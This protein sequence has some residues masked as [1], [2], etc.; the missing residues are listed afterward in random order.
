MS[1]PLK[2]KIDGL[3]VR[4]R[5]LVTVYALGWILGASLAAVLVLGL[6][7]YLLRFQDRG[8]R[9]ICFLVL[10]GVIGWS[11]YRY[12]VLGLTARLADVELARRLQRRFPKLGDGLASAVEFLQQSEEDPT[13]GSIALRRAVIA[14]TTAEVDQ[15]DVRS[16][17]RRGPTFRVIFTSLAICLVALV[18]VVVDPLSSRI[19]VARLINPFGNLAWPQTYHLVLCEEVTTVARGQAFEVEVVDQRGLRLP[20]DVRIHYRFQNAD[21]TVTEEAELMRLVDGA[22]A[23]RRSNGALD[24]RRR[25]GVMVARRE[26]VSRPFSYR[27]E[28]GD[29][30]VMPWIPVEVAEPPG[31]ESLAITL[32]PPEY[33]GW[34]AESAEEQIRALEGTRVEITARSTKPLKSAMFCLEG[35]RQIEARLAGEA[36]RELSV[37][38]VVDRS[39]AYWFKLTDVEGLAGGSDDRREIFAVP[40]APPTVSV[41]QPAADLFVTPE[42]EIPLRIVAKDDLAIHRLDVEFSRSDRPQDASAT[43]PLYAGP[44]RVEARAGGFS[45]GVEAGQSLV[46]PYQWRLAELGLESGMQV[47]FHATATDYRPNSRASDPRRL[48][49]ITPEELIERIAA[50]QAAIL[51]ELWRVLEMQRQS[52]GQV[53]ELE[54]QLAEVGRF[55]QFDV[56]RLRGAELNQRH[57][58]RTLTSR[59]E[60]VPAQILGLLADLENNKVDSADIQRQMRALLQEIDH[61]EREHLP[62]IERELT[63]AIKAAQVLLENPPQEETSPN[64]EGRPPAPD[65]I[66]S[67]SLVAAG[68]QQAQVIAVLE[69]LLDQLGRW[70]RYRQF[71]SKVSQLLRDQEDVANGTMELGRRTLTKDLDD[72]LPQ[73]SADLKVL[74]RR[75]FD[76]ARTLEEIERGMELASAQL[77]DANPL[78]AETVSDALYRARELAIS[79]QMRFAGER[80]QQNQIGQALQRQEQIQQSLREILDILSNR[81]EHELTRLIKQLRDAEAALEGMTQRQQTLHKEIDRADRQPDDQ[82]RR[83]E[84]ERVSPQQG[85]LQ[86]E[87]ERMARRLERLMAESAS[88]TTS[89][90]AEKMREA[91][92]SSRRAEGREASEQA[93]AAKRDLDEARRQLAERRRQAEADLA[94]EQ[95]ARLQETLEGMRGQQEKIVQETVRLDE[96]VRAQGQLTRPQAASLHGLARGQESLQAETT[97]LTEKLI[98]ADVFNLVLEDAAAEMAR[99]AAWLDLRKT[100]QP[101]QQAEQNALRRIG[102]LLDALAQEEPEEDAEQPSGGSGGTGG[103]AGAPGSGVQALAQLKLLKLLQLEV[104]LRTQTLENAFGASDSLT[105]EARRRYTELSD[106]QGRLADLLLNLIQPQGAPEDNPEGPPDGAPNADEDLLLPLDSEGSP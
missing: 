66:V 77:R 48:V 10:L 92:E 97:A 58:Q 15:L 65:P 73:E 83:R 90:A 16:A 105:D 79:G 49:I 39:G 20:S 89:K 40:D 22:I 101:T 11:C 74:A 25:N 81:R 12:L 9:V 98:G 60:G 5:R 41:E 84:L 55:N 71:H 34:P 94:L 1:H 80:V 82:Q 23:A 31:L 45:G 17:L 93:G 54:I 38:F 72:L 68:R 64:E 35:G 24:P 21:G 102:Q 32:I 36:N 8:V 76:L 96:L 104:N 14:Q 3:R 75:Q 78:F 61:L 91:A 56:D 100:G 47:T 88:R 44:D 57:V 63:S 28:G 2:R 87:A 43:I 95:M 99:A 33:T 18:L 37:D 7:D 29:D 85:Q 50:R 27:V 53:E 46:L 59:S 30:H 42:A 19:A 86:E 67:A 106:Q 70:D 69:E 62:I 4:V 26:N 52:R 13:A 51:S 103:Q 6:A